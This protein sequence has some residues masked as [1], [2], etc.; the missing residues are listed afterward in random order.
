MPQNIR[1]G[2]GNLIKNQS[3]QLIKASNQTK[4]TMTVKVVKGGDLRAK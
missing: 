4:D 2:N 3:T 1:S